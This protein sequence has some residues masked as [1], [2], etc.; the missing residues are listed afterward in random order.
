MPPVKRSLVLLLSCCTATLTLTGCSLEKHLAKVSGKVEAMYA[1]TKSWDSLPLRTITWREARAMIVRSNSDIINANNT[2]KDAE[3]QSL[4][5]YTDMIPGVSYYGYLTSSLDKLSETIKGE[6]ELSS[7]LNVN[8]SI[9]A[10]TQIPYR[11]Y[12]SKV[13]TFA[14]MKAR[15]GK[16][17]ELVSQLY[18]AVRLRH[19]R[20]R[21]QALDASDE[22]PDGALA[23]KAEKDALSAES[24]HWALMA[25]LLGDASARWEVLPETMPRVR[26]GDYVHKLDKLDPLVVCNYAMQMEQARMAQ[27]SIAL[28]YLPTVNTSLYS[29][30][31]FT[32]SGGT[33]SGTFLSGEDTKLNLSMSYTFD[34]DLRHWNDYQRS[35]QR[36]EQACRTVADSLREHKGK[37]DTLR[38]SVAEYERWRSFMLKRIAFTESTTPGSAEEYIEKKK[39]LLSM[40][41]ELLTQEASAVESEAALALEYGMPGDKPSTLKP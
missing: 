14:A 8:F 35:K 36:Y 41:R 30:S 1:E 11:V 6:N 13:T 25:K 34:T 33:Y 10:L 38:A 40:R 15:E 20:K 27:Y 21:Q 22:Q 26:W 24:S 23:I 17:R 19:I 39:S 29:P 2:I 7:N 4:S 32:S 9:P 16:E 31:L 3:R 5:V 28:R 37:V 18:K 12:S